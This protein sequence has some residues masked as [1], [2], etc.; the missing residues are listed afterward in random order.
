MRNKVTLKNAP[1]SVASLTE[2][3]TS[4]L[5]ASAIKA[6][7]TLVTDIAQDVPGQFLGDEGRIT[8]ILFN[9]TGNAMKFSDANSG[10]PS[11]I[12][13]L[14][15][16]ID[17]QKVLCFSVAD[18]GIGMDDDQVKRLFAPFTQFE[19]TN[20]RKFGGTGLGLFISYRLAELM[21]GRLDVESEQGVGTTFTL[22]LPY[23]AVEILN[24]DQFPINDVI[25][26]TDLAD[27]D[28]IIL[29]AE[30]NEV[31]QLVIR[32][33]LDKLGYR[34]IVVAN[35]RE[36]F[37]IWKTTPVSLV[38]TDCHMPVMDGYELA[39]EIRKLEK[40]E[41]RSATPIVA[42]TANALEGEA[43]KCLEAGMDGYL[44][45]PV[46]MEHLKRTLR[47]HLS[48]IRS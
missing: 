20:T 45:K 43:E 15:V 17:E 3:V 48:T 19:D 7:V 29:L 26:V 2:S 1:V 6:N 32:T 40:V 18:K 11:K 36:A 41:A 8:Q 23:Q 44:A 12:V 28:H 42:I 39:R 9:L 22:T 38:L 46:I 21:D 30:D 37:E 16:T 31:N 25:Q 34:S 4:L 13:R 33:Q 10:G 14:S 47:S 27:T 24:E 35:G 5:G